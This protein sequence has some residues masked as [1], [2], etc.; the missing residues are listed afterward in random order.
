MC[1]LQASLP[2][3]EYL[4]M[5]FDQAHKQY[6]TARHLPPPLYVLFVQATAYGQACGEYGGW[7]G[8]GLRESSHS[9]EGLPARRAPQLCPRAF[10]WQMLPPLC[11]L[12]M[13][14]TPASLRLDHCDRHVRM[15]GFDFYEPGCTALR[16]SLSALRCSLRQDTR[17]RWI[18]VVFWGVGCLVNSG[19]RQH[20]QAGFPMPETACMREC[21]VQVRGWTP[22]QS[23]QP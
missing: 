5:P 20:S 4:F 3:Q 8:R 15:D 14:A 7:A 22:G 13:A 9:E 17:G 6:E 18:S 23:A 2:V 12:S 16:C 19:P 1:C 21:S 11:T 10:G